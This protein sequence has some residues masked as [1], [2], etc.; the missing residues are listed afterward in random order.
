[1]GDQH[2]YSGYPYVAFSSTQ[3]IIVAVAPT[4][5][6]KIRINNYQSAIYGEQVFESSIAQWHFE[7]KEGE[8]GYFFNVFMKL[9]RLVAEEASL[10]NLGGLDLLIYS[11]FV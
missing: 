5:T 1:M 8:N 10:T 11:S 7:E 4:S 3:N 2:D 9:M 6:G